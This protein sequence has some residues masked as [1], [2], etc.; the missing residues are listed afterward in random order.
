MFKKALA[1]LLGLVTACFMIGY[2]ALHSSP[3]EEVRKLGSSSITEWL[4]AGPFPNEWGEDYPDYVVFDG[5]YKK[6]RWASFKAA[7]FFD[8]RWKLGK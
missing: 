8:G 2:P 1:T 5:E 3:A 7:G 4:M 6:M